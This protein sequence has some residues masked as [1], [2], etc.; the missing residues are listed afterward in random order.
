VHAPAARAEVDA[1]FRE[2]EDWIE[3]LR[4]QLG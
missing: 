4:S 3:A 2:A 1:S